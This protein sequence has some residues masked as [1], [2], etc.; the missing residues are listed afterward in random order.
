VLDLGASLA[1]SLGL[2]G[3]RL[4]FLVLII[5]CLLAAALGLGLRL[6]LIARAIGGGGGGS[7]LVTLLFVGKVN[8]FYTGLVLLR[9]LEFGRQ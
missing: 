1:T 6:L 4:L 8:T 3:L 5:F 7:L 9:V 2:L